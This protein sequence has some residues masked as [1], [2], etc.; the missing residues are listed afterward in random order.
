MCVL[1]NK[2]NEFTQI[3]V[4][5]LLPKLKFAIVRGQ[6][7]DTPIKPNPA[8]ANRIAR[9]VG[10]E[11]EEFLYVGDSNTDMKTADA[12]GMFPVGVLWGFRSK[13]ELIGAGAKALVQRPEEILRFF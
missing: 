10:V 5:E 9:E 2:S 8:G 12:A 6:S 3:I 1:S 11:N 7:E 13:E 4:R